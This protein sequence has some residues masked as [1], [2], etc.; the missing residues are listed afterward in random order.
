MNPKL[1]KIGESEALWDYVIG[2]EKRIEVYSG[3]VGR[4]EVRDGVVAG[5]EK[6]GSEWEG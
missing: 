1:L 6:G 5:D 4:R 2:N 3:G